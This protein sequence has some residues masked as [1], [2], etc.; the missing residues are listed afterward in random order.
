ME[1]E[2]QLHLDKQINK[3]ALKNNFDGKIMITQIF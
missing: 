3:K 2:S 1:L